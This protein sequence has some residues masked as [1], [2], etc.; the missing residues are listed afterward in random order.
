MTTRT[1]RWLLFALV[2]GFLAMSSSALEAVAADPRGCQYFGWDALDAWQQHKSSESPKA[3]TILVSPPIAPSIRV[4]EVIPSWNASTPGGSA[5]RTSIRAKIGERWTRWYEFGDWALD[6]SRHTR[7]SVP[8]QKDQDA[9]VDTDTLILAQ[10]PSTLEMRITLVA[11]QDGTQPKVRFVGLAVSDATALT[12]DLPPNREAWGRVLEVPERSQV[13]YPEGR[14]SWCSPTST[15]M[16][17][18]YWGQKLHRDGLSNLDVPEVA[19]GVNDPKWPGTGNWA[20]NMAYAGAMPGLRAYVVRLSDPSELEDWIV[21]GYPVAISVSYDYLRGRAKRRASD[22]HLV[23]CRGFT[24]KGEVVVNDPGTRSPVR[25]VFPREDL[26][27]GWGHSRFT[28]YVILPEDAQPPKDRFG[29]W[30]TRTGTKQADAPG[31][32]AGR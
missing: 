2:G 3:E 29:H 31:A 24:E 18:A 11:D 13:V 22:G 5:V 32:N 30:F 10:P 4:R 25:R 7:E 16:I 27:K 28:A 23:V 17:L 15:S 1:T 20:F 21:A 12:P 19:R 14:S 8:G 26:I 6:P 9:H